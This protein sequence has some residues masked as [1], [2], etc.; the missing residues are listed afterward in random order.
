MTTSEI[1]FRLY[2]EKIM[3]SMRIKIL[4]LKI[5]EKKCENIKNTKSLDF[6]RI[7]DFSHIVLTSF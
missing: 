1:F 4:A 7:F 3:I 5:I 6:T 2:Y